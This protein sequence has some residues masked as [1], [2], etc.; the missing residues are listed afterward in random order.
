MAQRYS[1]YIMASLSRRLYTGVTNN[2]LRRTVEHKEGR[3][4]GF[5]QQYRIN[6]LVYY[7]FFQYVR[8]A[9][10]REKQIKGWSRSKKVALIE[11]MNPAWADLSEE[12][13]GV[14]T[15]KEQ[16][17]HPKAGFGMAGP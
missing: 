4:P 15:K 13:S 11:S 14:R 12:W 9:I 17:P 10:A 1:V 6:R 8:P 7:E 16:I 3:I 5:T 2:L